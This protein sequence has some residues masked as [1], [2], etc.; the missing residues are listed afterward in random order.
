MVR[1]LCK[2]THRTKTKSNF[3]AKINHS[4]LPISHCI[5]MLHENPLLTAVDP[6]SKDVGMRQSYH[7]AL[8]TSFDNGSTVISSRFNTTSSQAAYSCVRKIIRLTIE[9]LELKVY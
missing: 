5:S 2:T 6:L 3:A 9:R 4:A 7:M 8:P 1:L